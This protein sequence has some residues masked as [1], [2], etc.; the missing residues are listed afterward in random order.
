[1]FGCCER[2][3]KK[4]K[5]SFFFFPFFLIYIIWPEILYYKRTWGSS[6]LYICSLFVCEM[7]AQWRPKAENR[8]LYKLA[9]LLKSFRSQ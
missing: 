4:Y 8:G 7:T 2:C 6:R 1:M 9:K 5:N 3:L